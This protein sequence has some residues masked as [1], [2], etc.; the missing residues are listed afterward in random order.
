MKT[1]ITAILLIIMLSLQT[2]SF[3]AFND[4]DS[5]SKVGTAINQLVN[6]GILSG[7]PDGTFRPEGLLTRAQFAKIAVC[8][9]DAEKEAESLSGISVFGDVPKNHWANGYINCIAQRGIINGYPDGTFGA[10]DTITYAQALTILVRLLGYEGQDVNYNWPEGYIKKAQSLGITEGM[11]FGTY[12]NV[13]RGNAAYIIYNTLFA[14]KKPGSTIDILSTT[15][16]EDVVIYA[17]SSINVAVPDDAILTTSGTYKLSGNIAISKDVY[18]KMGT[19]YIDSEK[20]VISFVPD[21][22]SLRHI[23]ITSAIVSGDK[24]EITFTE[25]GVTKKEKFDS[26]LTV[27]INGR[28]T[29]LSGVQLEAGVEITLFYTE[30]GSLAR[31]WMKETALAGPVTIMSD[32]SQVYSS[33]NISGTMPRTIRDGKNAT[34][35]DVELYD[36][37]YYMESTNTLYAYSEKASGTYEEAYPYK[38]DV[39]SVKVGGREYTLATQNAIS[40]MDTSAGAF[41]IGDRVTLLFGKNKEVVDVVPVSSDVSL[42]IVV[43][44]RSYKKISTDR[45]NEGASTRYIDVTLADGT[46]VTYEADRDY[47]DHIGDVMKIEFNGSV[48]KLTYVVPTVISGEFDK[49]IPSLDGHWFSKDCTILELT[50]NDGDVAT[51]KK[52]ELREIETTNLNSNQVIHAYTSGT[53]QDIYF[54]YV[55]DVTKT[56]AT[57]GVVTKINNRNYTIL[58]DDKTINIKT[59]LLIEISSAVEIKNTQDGQMVEPLFKIATG[60]SIEGFESGRIR[61]GGKNYLISD[62]VKVYGASSKNGYESMSLSQIINDK[63]LR[64]IDLFSDKPLSSG[65]VIRAIVVSLQ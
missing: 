11:T 4:V 43:L 13:T 39:T 32:Y 35:S 19:L 61:V 28:E 48:A 12:E 34:L 47:S 30:S 57:Y 59:S 9:L 62:Y 23:L 33:F 15:S 38:S 37:V 27:Y 53:M 60:D 54:L 10:E 22:E 45:E 58:V 56:D 8:M 25:N 6:L 7:Y 64:K 16:V 46:E 24:I 31:A 29:T 41:E 42:D 40:K 14:D 52:I 44:T 49:N 65:G 18:G 63:N 1:K 50:G 20:K 2:V 26:G 51:V 3:A 5:T 55:K 17:D 36:V 21:N